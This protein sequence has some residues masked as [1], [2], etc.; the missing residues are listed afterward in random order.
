MIQSQPK[1]AFNAVVSYTDLLGKTHNIQC[2]TRRQIKE[3]QSFLAQ[4][5]RDY[6]IVKQIASQ[7][8]VKCGKYVNAY[9]LK[10]DLMEAGFNRAFVQRIMA[11]SI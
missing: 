5:K 4:F 10:R 8:A 2:R 3:A 1:V 6:S 7:Y 11:S 9:K